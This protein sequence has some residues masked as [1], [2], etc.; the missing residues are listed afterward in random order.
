MD[1]G[2]GEAFGPPKILSGDCLFVR[3]GGEYRF[4]A[5]GS[6][7]YGCSHGVFAK[8]VGNVTKVNTTGKALTAGQRVRMDFS[9][10]AESGRA[11][12]PALVIV[13]GGESLEEGDFVVVED[14]QPGDYVHLST[15]SLGG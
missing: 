10:V 11:V 13:S 3:D 2:G 14:S 8:I 1:S 12:L 5:H 7:N 6:Q 4:A 15:Y 9:R